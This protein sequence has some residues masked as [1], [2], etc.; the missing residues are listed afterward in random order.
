MATASLYAEENLISTAA[1]LP[2]T[3]FRESYLAHVEKHGP[4]KI[5]VIVDDMVGTGRSLSANMKKFHDDNLD[6]LAVDSPFALLATADGQR[7]VLDALSK[8]Q[9]PNL[10]FRAGEILGKDAEIFAGEKGVFGTV[11]EHDRAK[12][13]ATDIGASI[14]RDAPLGFGD[15]GLAVVLP[16]TVPNNSLPLLHSRGKGPLPH[17]KPL[18]ERLIN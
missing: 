9:Y 7:A 8:L 13:V 16:T 17:W 5:V 10:N 2:P 18:F 14:Y 1:I 6:A 11:E 3:S 15:Q 12:M 4:P